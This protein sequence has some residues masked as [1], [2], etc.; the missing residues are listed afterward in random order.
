MNASDL[1]TL[2][3]CPVCRDSDLLGLEGGLADGMLECSRCRATYPVRGGIPILLPSGLDTSHIH[4]EVDHLCQH[5][6]QQA[7]YFDREVAV[8]FEIVAPRRRPVGLPVAD[9]RK[10]PAQRC[11][12]IACKR[13]NGR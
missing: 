6:R 7:N 3:T 12:V 13:G 9:G 8:E 10:V 2:L 5:K 11:T 4:D 1:L